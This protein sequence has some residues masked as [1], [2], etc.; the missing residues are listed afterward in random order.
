MYKRF[1][2]SFQIM[3]MLTRAF[4]IPGG[5]I[6]GLGN[7]ISRLNIIEEI[8]QSFFVKVNRIYQ[9]YTFKFI[10]KLIPKTLWILLH[11]CSK[12]FSNPVN[13]FTRPWNR[14]MQRDSI[15]TA[16][17]P[18]TLSKIML[19]NLRNK[20]VF[21][22]LAEQSG[23]SGNPD[24]R[25]LDPL[26]YPFI[27]PVRECTYLWQFRLPLFFHSIRLKFFTGFQGV[28]SLY[29]CLYR[30]WARVSYVPVYHCWAL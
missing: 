21:V 2:T 5:H 16:I 27:T 15:R 10:S 9:F 22:S 26:S 17:S 1:S 23:I 6:L 20:N 24:L 12:F 19:K 14:N 25:A 13:F 29:F 8:L 4:V 30:F 11:Q 7:T 3:P 28:S 18:I